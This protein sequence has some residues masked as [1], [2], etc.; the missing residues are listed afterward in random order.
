MA[1]VGFSRHNHS[2]CIRQGLDTADIHCKSRGLKFTPIRRRVLEILL[3]AHNAR[4]AYEILDRLR[5]EGFGSQPPVVYRALDFLVA[6]G[7]AHKIEHLN[8]FVACVE[9]TSDHNPAFLICRSCNSIVET[10]ADLGKGAMGRMVKSFGFVAEKSV[11][12]VEGL[13]GLCQS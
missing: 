1:E 13:C 4:G 10:Q 3:A 5:E 6:N 11:V 7:F 8:A 12:E 2:A 9:W